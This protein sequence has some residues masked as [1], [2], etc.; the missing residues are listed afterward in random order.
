MK[1]KFMVTAALPYANGPLH[2]GHIAGAYLPS[3]IFVRYQRALNHDV[4]FICGADEH[5]VPI[6]IQAE[7]M[8]ITPQQL[9][10]QNYPLIK[11]TF[12]KLNIDFS[13]FSRTSNP[14]HHKT[15]AD[16]FKLLYDKGLFEEKKTEQF[17]DEKN[18]QFLADRYITGT[19]PK[20]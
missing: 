12:E 10:D 9:V 3:D 17:Y 18:N 7:K 13:I 11:D 5:G 20:M 1:K 14:M 6:T 15:A 8:G 16:L 2:L 19:C 4:A